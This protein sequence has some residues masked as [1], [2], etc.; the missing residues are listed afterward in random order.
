MREGKLSHPNA[1]I[2]RFIAGCFRFFTLTQFGD[3]PGRYGRFLRFDTSPSRE[4]VIVSGSDSL[5]IPTSTGLPP[6]FTLHALL[7]GKAIS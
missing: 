4:L 7:L 6:H 2:T 3:R 5:T 1:S